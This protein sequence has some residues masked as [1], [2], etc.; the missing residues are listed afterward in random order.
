MSTALERPKLRDDLR[1]VRQVKHGEVTYV[2]K[3][4]ATQDYYK[5]SAEEFDIVT[6]LDGA[7]DVAGVHRRYASAHPDVEV[8]KEEIEQY[9]KSLDG[10]KLLERTGKEKNQMLVER[11]REA[12]KSKV[13]AAKG[14]VTYMR[15]PI[16]DPDQFFNRTI[17]Y[18]RF[19]WRPWF[20]VVMV[21]MMA[22]ASLVIAVK[23]DEVQ[24]G[25][26]AVFSFNKSGEQWLT[27][28]LTVFT[29]ICLHELA[30]GY[31][32]KHFGGEVH[33]L[34]FL[35]LFFQP[36]MYANISDAWTFPERYKR[37]CATIAGG[38]FEFFIGAICAFIWFATTA[39]SSLNAVMYQAMCVC[40]FSTVA[41]N[42]NPMMK[43]DGYY[44]MCDLLETP[45]MKQNSLGFLKTMVRRH[46]FHLKADEEWEGYTLAERRAYFIYGIAN[47]IYMAGLLTGLWLLAEG[48][49]VSF[50][51]EIGLLAALWVAWKLF[52]AFGKKFKGFVAELAKANEKTIRTRRAKGVLAAAL[53]LL[54]AALLV[55][56]GFDLRQKCA[57]EPV[58]QATL[59]ARVGGYLNQVLVR[60]GDAV[61]AGQLLA[62]IEN[63]NVER[64]WR[65]LDAEVTGVSRQIGEAASQGDPAR[66]RALQTQLGQARARLAEVE[67]DL[68]EMR[69][70]APFEGIVVTP[71]LDQRQG[72]YVGPGKPVLEIIDPRELLISVPVEER[73]VNRVRVGDTLEVRLK[74]MPAERLLST[75]TQI[76][77]RGEKTARTDVAPSYYVFAHV[78]NP[79]TGAL[80]PGMTGTASINVGS[81]PLYEDLL[82][83]ASKTL[84]VDLLF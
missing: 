37:V 57:V 17:P 15:I 73:E 61:A 55:P 81:R 69:I 24:R 58:R 70:V 34:G 2:V 72:E 30:H 23:W 19:F 27:L 64:K 8:K 83:R 63:R 12:R 48:L 45:N 1:I 82:D 9:L 76:T 42:F 77:E 25:I 5:F 35:F 38:Y 31:T 29:V 41:V 53:V 80:R 28:W 16:F 54:L 36:C 44:L 49:A 4:P 78:R 21:G 46:V 51:D 7:S 59:S 43:L 39:E 18:L 84:K 67:K 40:G 22:L 79:D 26:D 74:A 68:A 75:V 56:V 62:V 32:C 14:S 13:F 11:A 52:G 3:D 60:E 66:F 33:E 65:S 47:I 50:L 20:Q 10:L 71:N 6:L